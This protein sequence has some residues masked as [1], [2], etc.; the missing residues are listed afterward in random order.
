MTIQLKTKPTDRLIE[1]G[2]GA[3]PLI[4]PNCDV[5][6]CQG[7]DG[8]S[9]VDV[10]ADFEYFL[11]F[12]DQEFDGIFSQY[13]LEHISY[14]KI[15]QFLSEI[16]RILAPGGKIVIVT[17]NTEAQLEWLRSHP[18]GWDDKDYYTA[19]SELLFGSQ[20][21][22]E[23]THKNFFSPYILKAVFE[24]AGFEQIKTTPYGARDTDIVV[25]AV[26]SYGTPTLGP[27]PGQIICSGPIPGQ[28]ELWK[29]IQGEAIKS[30]ITSGAG[31]QVPHVWGP[32]DPTIR[33]GEAAA[34]DERKADVLPAPN[35]FGTNTERSVQDTVAVIEQE[36]EKLE[37]MIRP[38]KELMG[39]KKLGS[40]QV[41]TEQ[42]SPQPTLPNQTHP[43][44]TK[45]DGTGPNRSEISQYT[46]TELFSKDYFNG[47]KRFGGYAREGYRD[48]PV[49]EITTQHILSR[50]PES[51]LEIGAARGYILKRL[52]D[53]GIRVAGLE[54]S[55]HCYLSR[56]VDDVFL[57]DICQTPWPIPDQSFDCCFSIATMEH[58]PEDKLPV[59]LGEIK[60]TCKW[61]LHGIDFGEKDDGFDR[62]HC[63]LKSKDWWHTVF[64]RHLGVSLPGSTAHMGMYAP[65]EIV[66]KESLEQGAFPEEVL[67]GDGKCKLNLGCFTN[68]YHYGWTNIDQHDLASFAQQQGYQFQRLDIRNGL[69]FATGSVDLIHMSHFLE[70]L[71]VKEGL[72]CLKECRRVIKPDGA[73]RIACPDT[74]LLVHRYAKGTLDDFREVSDGVESSPTQAGKLWELLFSGHQMAYDKLTICQVLEE[75]G[76]V[77]RPTYF[78][79]TGAGKAG[80][81][82]LRETLEIVQCLTCFVDALPLLG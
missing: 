24:R 1:L 80:G 21:Y 76:F 12:G 7:P 39:E 48:F 51:V 81:Q 79:K 43:N 71:S 73:I 23:N 18:D 27:I 10:I 72:A 56:V 63:T 47:G 64:A 37:Q 11:P 54:V 41:A 58:I 70:H 4:R 31:D 35:V 8:N 45:P 32:V 28:E 69:P 33:K 9:T 77:P 52:Q 42:S 57:H 36:N 15:P 25:E 82:I 59:V 19:S 66:S 74:E 6:Q 13:A 60:R 55:K 75:S 38:V 46:A 40:Q 5:R 67:K 17:A 53:H 26:K 30:P 61:G 16:H 2:G 62:T 50:R 78:R 22:P 14:P 3:R 68:M 34:V 49:H 20:D 65:Y 29:R 44:L